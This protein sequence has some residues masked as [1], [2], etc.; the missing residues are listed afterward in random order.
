MSI[1]KL[2]N[3]A[4]GHVLTATNTNT[5]LISKHRALADALSQLQQ[6]REE[7]RELRQPV[8]QF[9]DKL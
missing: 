4:I 5:T 7:L 1:E 6:A 3:L 2:I 8:M 9:L